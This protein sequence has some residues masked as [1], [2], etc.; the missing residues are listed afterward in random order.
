MF[1]KTTFLAILVVLMASMGWAQ[2]A[3]TGRVLLEAQTEVYTA[4]LK[5]Y[6]GAE[7]WEGAFTYFLEAGEEV[8]FDF[9]VPSGKATWLIV[10]YGDRLAL[11][12]MDLEVYEGNRLVAQDLGPDAFAAVVINSS[13]KT[14]LTMLL[15]AFDTRN[16][17][18][19]GGYMV[20][21]LP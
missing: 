8:E 21:E 4:V 19:Y 2:T 3:A 11:K 9:E 5:A 14:T 6:P 13:G 20:F 16:Q 1:R 7:L 12:D 17:D 15:R 10:A 18:G